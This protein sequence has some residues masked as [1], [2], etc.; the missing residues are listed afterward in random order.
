MIISGVS[1]PANQLVFQD[2]NQLCT[3]LPLST[4]SS[5]HSW[6]HLRSPF[7][8]SPF[9]HMYT[10]LAYTHTSTPSFP[11]FHRF[12]EW[13]NRYQ[14]M[15][16]LFLICRGYW[17]RHLIS[18][19]NY[20]FQFHNRWSHRGWMSW[21]WSS[22]YQLFRLIFYSLFHFIR[23]FMEIYYVQGKFPHELS[24]SSISSLYHHL[25]FLFPL[26]LHLMMLFSSPTPSPIFMAL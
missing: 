18:C 8:C 2:P 14:K 9:V 10:C 17:C 12:F 7:S 21:T 23:D 20:T 1:E 4:P 25:T 26:Q 13:Y 19:R 5:P 11:S 15:L 24:R 6:N 22:D 16:G 3:L